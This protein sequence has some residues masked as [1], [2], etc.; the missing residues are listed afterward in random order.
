MGC[1]T[2]TPTKTVKPDPHE[3]VV[4]VEGDRCLDKET[5]LEL[6]AMPRKTMTVDNPELEFSRYCRTYEGKA[7]ITILSISSYSIDDFWKDFLLLRLKGI[8]EATIYLNSPG[9]EAFQG[10]ALTDEIRLAKKDIKLTVEC[11][12]LIASAA[13]PVLCAADHRI[14]SKGTFFML[15][16]AALTKWGFF[17]EGLKDLRSQTKMIEL[18]N[19]RYA[20]V[21]A[22]NTS[23]TKEEVLKLMEEDNWFTAEEALKMGL[24]HEIK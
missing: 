13:I 4:T 2:V 18:L 23:L 8:K 7:Y 22:E 6:A 14:G 16:P 10:I 24:L 15:H 1:I 19:E 20:L 5:I 12:G 9:G 17:T 3:L 11:R 21:V